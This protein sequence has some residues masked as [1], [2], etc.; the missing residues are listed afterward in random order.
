MVRIIEGLAADWRRFALQQSFRPY[1]PGL[2]PFKSCLTATMAD[3]EAKLI[4]FMRMVATLRFIAFAIV[5][6]GVLSRE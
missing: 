2:G 1:T 4:G 5:E 6:T 3:R